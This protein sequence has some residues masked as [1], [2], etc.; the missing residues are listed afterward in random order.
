MTVGEWV[1]A[2]VAIFHCGI[3]IVHLKLVRDGGEASTGR[4]SRSNEHEDQE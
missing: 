4:S 1:L 3:G 2:A